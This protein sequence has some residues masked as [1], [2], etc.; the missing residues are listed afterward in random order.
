[1]VMPSRGLGTAMRTQAAMAE[2]PEE[3]RGLA[4]PPP[5]SGVFRNVLNKMLQTTYYTGYTGAGASEL[6]VQ[7]AETKPEGWDSGPEDHTLARPVLGRLA[8]DQV[9]GEQRLTRRDSDMGTRL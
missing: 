8:Q 7:L 6:W 3:G 4:A 9:S 2:E 5:T 1:M